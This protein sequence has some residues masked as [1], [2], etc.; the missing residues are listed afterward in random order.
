MAT[1]REGLQYVG[2]RAPYSSI[3]RVA[4]ERAARLAW[5]TKL[6]IGILAGQG[7]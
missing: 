5:R 7:D 3:A 6:C 1:E 2:L 4:R